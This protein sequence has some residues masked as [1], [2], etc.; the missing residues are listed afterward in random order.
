MPIE[1]NMRGISFIT[2]EDQHHFGV[3]QKKTGKQV[4]NEDAN[5]LV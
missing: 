4:E 2:E 5:E 3:I 1:I